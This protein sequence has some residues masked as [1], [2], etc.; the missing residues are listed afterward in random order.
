[1]QKTFANDFVNTDSFLRG[2]AYA[3]VNLTWNTFLISNM[4][5]TRICVAQCGRWKLI[6]TAP[7]QNESKMSLFKFV[8][9]LY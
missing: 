9:V 3:Y 4:R 8:D 1:M 6:T 5:K 2:V 7:A